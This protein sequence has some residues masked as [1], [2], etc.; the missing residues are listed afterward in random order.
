MI[1]ENT[2]SSKNNSCCEEL[3][4]ALDELQQAG[5]YTAE[6]ASFFTTEFI[7]F[8]AK[9]LI[10]VASHPV[11]YVQNFVN[12]NLEIA[13]ELALI[14]IDITTIVDSRFPDEVRQEAHM[15]M[16]DRVETITTLYEG[17]CQK[18]P[19]MS[20][21]EWAQLSSRI[22][23]DYLV[24]KGAGKGWHLAKEIPTAIQESRFLNHIYSRTAS[25]L[26]TMPEVATAEG[27]VFKVSKGMEETSTLMHEAEK[28]LITETIKP[29]DYTHSV[30]QY[31]LLKATLQTEEF[32][33][34]I[35]VTKHGLERL[36]ERG[37]EASEVL[38]LIKKPSLIKIQADGSKAFVKELSTGRYNLLVINEQTEKVIT[39]LKNISLNKLQNI[40]Q[41]YGWEIK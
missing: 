17:A 18:I 11:S 8:S 37:F 31:E 12:A 4:Q 32:T 40:G 26:E 16:Q 2:L 25:I 14:S 15:R 33:S 13:K 38:D 35:K 7:N 34:I 19:E 27:M 24:F 29:L 21:T 3:S 6:Q 10:D 22:F 1:I 5:L 20:R 41:N 23:S 30:A 28:V 9:N 36:I 39:A